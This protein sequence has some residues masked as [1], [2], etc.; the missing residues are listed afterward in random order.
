MGSFAR[1]LRDDLF[2]WMGY[3]SK[4][5]YWT[6]YDDNTYHYNQMQYWRDRCKSAEGRLRKMY[7]DSP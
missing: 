1:K 6:Q 2:G 3:V 7:E 4:Q 5:K